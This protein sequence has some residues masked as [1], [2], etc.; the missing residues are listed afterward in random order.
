M[1]GTNLETFYSFHMSLVLGSYPRYLVTRVAL[2]QILVE[3]A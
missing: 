3:D 1:R 2:E